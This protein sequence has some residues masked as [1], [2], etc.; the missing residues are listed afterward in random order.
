MIRLFLFAL[1]LVSSVGVYAASEV[2]DEEFS[3][4]KATADDVSLVMSDAASAEDI[5]DFVSRVNA[6]FPCSIHGTYF[7]YKGATKIGVINLSNAEGEF[8]A[9]KASAYGFSSGE[10]ACYDVF[11]DEGHKGGGNFGHLHAK[12]ME[13]VAPFIGEKHFVRNAA[14]ELVESELPFQGIRGLIDLCNIP[15]LRATSKVGA[16]LVDIPEDRDQWVMQFFAP[17]RA[18]SE[19]ELELRRVADIIIHESLDSFRT[20][21]F[22][23]GVIPSTDKSIAAVSNHYYKNKILFPDA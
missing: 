6:S 12:V 11:L 17:Q 21:P 2:V 7:A 3:L 16:T 4:R 22:E 10:Y 18:L 9:D 23:Y 1:F 14:N 8:Y 20:V 13:L 5:N 15:S 19:R